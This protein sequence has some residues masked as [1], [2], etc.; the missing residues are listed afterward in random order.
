MQFAEQTIKQ[1]KASKA[2]KTVEGIIAQT[3]N[4]GFELAHDTYNAISLASDGNIYYILSSEEI[5][6]GGKMYCYHTGSD[7]IEYLGDLTEICGESGLHAISQG[8]SHV[9]FYEMDGKLYFSTHVGFYEMIDGMERM[10]VNHLM[11]MAC[12]RAGIFCHS[13]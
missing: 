12:I 13:I 3:F 11:V 5:T 7:H 4:S 2:Q 10:P 6:I 9:R 1:E 8:K